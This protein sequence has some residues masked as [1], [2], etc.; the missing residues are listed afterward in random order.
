MTLKNDGGS[1]KNLQS[2][3]DAASGEDEWLSE[4]I[5]YAHNHGWLVA[6]FRPAQTTKGWRTAMQGNPGYPDLTLA[7]DGVVVFAELKASKK[8]LLTVGQ[9]RWIEALGPYAYVWTPADRAEMEEVL[10]EV[11]F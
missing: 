5:E 7:R 4:V 8:G 2:D 1:I 3:M 6:H 11:S 9:E 10:H